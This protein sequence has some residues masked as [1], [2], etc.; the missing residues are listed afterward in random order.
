MSSAFLAV[1]GLAVIRPGDRQAESPNPTGRV[2]VTLPARTP[3]RAQTRRL[4][5]ILQA[6]RLTWPKASR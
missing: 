4:P 5:A 6:W 1:V 2:D 3:V